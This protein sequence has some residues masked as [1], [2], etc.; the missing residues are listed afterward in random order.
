MIKMTEIKKALTVQNSL[1]KKEN[2]TLKK[3]EEELDQI[4]ASARKARWS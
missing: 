2:D 4:L 3:Q 1:L